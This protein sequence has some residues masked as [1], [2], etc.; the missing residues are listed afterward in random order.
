VKYLFLSRG[1]HLVWDP[2]APRGAG[3]AEMQ[4]ALMARELVRL[5]HRSVLLGADTGQSDG[6]EWEGIRIRNGGS[7]ETGK[8]FDTLRAW[9]RILAILREEE[10]DCVV[11]YGWTALLYALAWW[12]K[13]AP[14]KLVFVCALDAEIDGDFRR[15]H[16]VRGFFF[17]RGMQ[18]ADVRLSIT[19]AQAADFARQGMDCSVTRLL[20]REN[21]CG[22]VADKPVDLLWVARC[23]DVKRPGLFLDLA[24]ALPQA[25][26]RMI[27]A[28]HDGGLLAA[29]KLRA[30]SISNV[31]FVDGVAYREIQGEFDRAKVFVNTSSHEGVPNTFV[32]AGLGRTAI[33]SLEIDPDKMFDNFDAGVMAG[34]SFGKL[35]SG[36]RALLE[37][38]AKLVKAADESSRFVRECHDNARNV[39]SFLA[40]TAA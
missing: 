3:G 25:R 34:G 1:A 16:P 27:C 21:A 23:E 20:L 28:P 37:S 29:T 35:Q 33:A 11:V 22:T 39:Q 15:R 26:C 9:P 24:E 12:K 10:P 19:A 40:A 32:H 18:K 38:D 4:A 14:F 17:H 7:Y 8:I 31:Q 5:G 13:I 30:A 6:V 36:V 2:A